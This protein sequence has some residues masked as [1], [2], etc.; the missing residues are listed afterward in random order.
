MG[1]GSGT[2]FSHFPYGQG[3]GCLLPSPP[4][5]T[6]PFGITLASARRGS[7]APCADP[8][9]GV[10]DDVCAAHIIGWPM[11]N[12]DPGLFNFHLAAG[13]R[14]G[15]DEGKWETV[16]SL[17]LF[18]LRASLSCPLVVI[19]SKAVSLGLE[20]LRHHIAKTIRAKFM[21]RAI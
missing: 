1:T 15:R 19:Q 6:E 20:G 11:S 5:P 8:L 4:P 12:W 2:G 9:L 7:P 18:S 16:A 13:W 3:A 21:C 14:K 17:F 10:V